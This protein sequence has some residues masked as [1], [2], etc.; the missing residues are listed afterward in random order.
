MYW[1][2]W[3]WWWWWLAGWN[4]LSAILLPGFIGVCIKNNAVWERMELLPVLRLVLLYSDGCW[5]CLRQLDDIFWSFSII[6]IAHSVPTCSLS[7]SPFQS[8]T[9]KN[10]HI[11][12]HACHS[13]TQTSCHPMSSQKNSLRIIRLEIVPIEFLPFMENGVW[14]LC[15]FIP[16]R[17]SHISIAFLYLRF[18]F[19]VN[20]FFGAHRWKLCMSFMCV[21][22]LSKTVLMR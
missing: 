22:A 13:L 7:L 10:V 20:L 2:W 3:W 1:W 8:P 11:I 16:T 14:F 19:S 15:I 6:T 17:L 9:Q 21:C 18:W 12:L 4:I 5:W